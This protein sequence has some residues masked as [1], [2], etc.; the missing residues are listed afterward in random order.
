MV[1]A[2]GLR[3]ER[4]LGCSAERRYPRWLFQEEADHLAAGVRPAG[5]G[6]RSSGTPTRPCVADSVK[7]PMLQY[8]APTLIG[9]NGPGVIYPARSLAPADGGPEIRR[10]FR[11]GNDLVAV[12]RVE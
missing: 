3:L 10:G 8:R 4:A 12:N 7:H 5:L 6:I 1:R 9:L 11:L 2:A